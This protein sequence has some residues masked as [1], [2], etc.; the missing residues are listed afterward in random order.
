MGKLYGEIAIDLQ[1]TISFNLIYWGQSSVKV[2]VDF[3]RWYKA[4]MI[5]T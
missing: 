3:E 1:L 5:I 4:E 2:E